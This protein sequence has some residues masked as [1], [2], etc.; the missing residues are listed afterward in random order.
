MASNSHPSKRPVDIAPNLADVAEAAELLKP[1]ERMQLLARL[2]ESLPA[3]NR[4][5]IVTYGIENVHR[6]V[7]EAEQREPLEPPAEPPQLE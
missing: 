7:A 1:D 2:W 4:A 5:A 3:R 6:L